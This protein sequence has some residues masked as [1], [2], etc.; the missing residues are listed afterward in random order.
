M[1]TAQE[2]RPMSIDD[3][4]TALTVAQ[5]SRD[6]LAAL[7]ALEAAAKAAAERVRARMAKAVQS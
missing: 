3:A 5:S 7:K 4:M 2:T 6:T 1:S